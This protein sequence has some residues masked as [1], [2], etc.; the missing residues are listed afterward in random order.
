MLRRARGKRS[1]GTERIRSR[2]RWV[3]AWWRATVRA[4][5]KRSRVSSEGALRRRRRIVRRRTGRRRRR[6]RR[7]RLAGRCW[8]RLKGLG[9]VLRGFTVLVI[10]IMVME[11]VCV[12]AML[13]VF[14]GETGQ[15][16][17]RMHLVNVV[18]WV[19]SEL[20]AKVMW[21]DHHFVIF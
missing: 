10:M 21:V 15:L 6:R 11:I 9:S 5:R 17:G 8:D 16:L 1:L 2:R 14:A 7:K 19:L 12:L 3:C 13:A 20:E 4:R 18:L